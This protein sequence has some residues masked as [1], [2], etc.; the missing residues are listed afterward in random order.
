MEKIHD[1][2]TFIGEFPVSGF[3]YGSGYELN[4]TLESGY[5]RV[6][7]AMN[8]KTGKAYVLLYNSIGDLLT[9]WRF[10]HTESTSERPLEK[11]SAEGIATTLF[12]RALTM[13]AKRKNA[14]KVPIKAMV[15]DAENAL[16]IVRERR[17]S[18]PLV[19]AEEEMQ[20]LWGATEILQNVLKELQTITP[21]L[22]T[23]RR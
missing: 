2:A 9:E 8:K 4:I 18:L 7:T 23:K 22:P 20:E 10:Y 15:A 17:F 3:E 14:W 16:Q 11:R 19:G 5:I 1:R 21:P 12:T 6:E 13:Q